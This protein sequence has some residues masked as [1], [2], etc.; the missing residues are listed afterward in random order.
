MPT[1]EV[2]KPLTQIKQYQVILEGEL[3]PVTVDAEGTTRYGTIKHVEFK[4]LDEDGNQAGNVYFSHEE[5]S[6][7]LKQA[8]V[9]VLLTHLPALAG[10][11]NATFDLT[12]VAFVPPVVEEV[13]EEVVP[14]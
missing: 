13:I 12:P 6:D 14:E 9:T 11:I 8:L 1:I 5:L 7:E 3:P 4:G 10:E 2:K